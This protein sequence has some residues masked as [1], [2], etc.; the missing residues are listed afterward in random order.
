MNEDI[1]ILDAH[2]LFSP[3]PLPHIARDILGGLVSAQALIEAELSPLEFVV[4]EVLPVGLTILGGAPKSGKSF[5]A[6]DI[7]KAVA[8]GT[9]L[10]GRYRSH[11]G[12]VLYITYEDT[13]RRLQTRLRQKTNASDSVYLSCLLFHYR[14]P[15]FEHQGLEHLENLVPKIEGIKLVVID[16]LGCFV[17]AQ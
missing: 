2:D 17:T 7:A 12:K 14:W 11:Q 16:T 3:N 9:D 4:N 6:L 13:E 5:L 8:S 10:L 15:D 1:V